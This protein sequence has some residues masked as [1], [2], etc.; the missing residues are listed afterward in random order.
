MAAGSTEC[1]MHTCTHKLTHT[2][3]GASES[4]IAQEARS[5]VRA[6]AQGPKAKNAEPGGASAAAPTALV[7]DN[8]CL[9][10]DL[11]TD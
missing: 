4:R 2:G 3:G 6:V 1:T 11:S 10:I 7:G 8:T 5:L 9:R